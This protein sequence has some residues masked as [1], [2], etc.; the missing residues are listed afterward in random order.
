MQIERAGGRPGKPSVGWIM[1]GTDPSSGSWFE[2]WFE[3]REKAEAHAA[4]RGWLT[5]ES[6][7][8]SVA[9]HITRFRAEARAWH[10]DHAEG[11]FAPLGRMD[12]DVFIAADSVGG[13][14]SWRLADVDGAPGPW[15]EMDI[16][17]RPVTSA[18]FGS[19]EAARS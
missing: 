1:Y 19:A 17:A 13:R 10:A 2:R 12:G 16:E 9:R 8:S 15:H 11:Q 5:M 14:Y 7:P 4:R 6:P 3:T 18:Q